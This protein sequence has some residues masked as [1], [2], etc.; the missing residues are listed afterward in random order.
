MQMLF[1]RI[2]DMINPL[3]IL[4]RIICSNAYYTLHWSIITNNLLFVEIKVS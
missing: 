1:F 4:Q 2:N 3:I